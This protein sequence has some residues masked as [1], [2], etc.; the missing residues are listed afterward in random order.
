M[1]STLHGPSFWTSVALVSCVAGLVAGGAQRGAGAG[2]GGR[3]AGGA[4]GAG[5]GQRRG[6]PPPPA[7]PQDPNVFRAGTNLVPLDVRV[8][9][10]KGQPITDLTQAD[11]TVVENGVAQRIEHFA[12]QTMTPDPAL[13]TGPLARRSDQTSAVTPRNYR[14]FLIYLGRGDL[15]GPANGIDG[16]IHFVGERLLPQDRVA[17]FAWNRATDFTTN[18][19][20][21]LAVLQ[22][23]KDGY[24]GVERN[25]SEYFKTPAWMYGNRQIPKNIQKDIDQIFHGPEGAPTRTLGSGEVGNSDQLARAGRAQQERD[26]REN[27]DSFTASSNDTFAAQRVQNLGLT[28]EEFLSQTAQTMQDQANLFAGI[29]YLKH[30]DGE[31]HL[32]MV[33]EQG[34]NMTRWEYDRDLARAASDARVVM[35]VIRTGGTINTGGGG[36]AEL[37]SAPANNGFA[38]LNSLRPAAS[39]AL[40]A[41]L[42]GGRSDANKFSSAARAADAID[43]ASRSQYLIGYYPANQR[44]DG[45]FR[46]INVFVNRKGATVLVRRGYYATDQEGAFDRQSV[47]TYS[48]MIAAAT[49]PTELPDLGLTVT[50]TNSRAATGFSVTVNVTMDVSR[51]HFAQANGRRDGSVEVAVFCLDKKQTPL[52]EVHRTVQLSFTDARYAEVSKAGVPVS[53]TIPVGVEAD[54]VKV[55]AYDYQADLTGSRNFKIEKAK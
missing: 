52:G 49:T 2:Q 53:F 48:R 43:E 13:A 4:R 50:A 31:K 19:D 16:L 14:V 32:L 12:F 51:V 30:L 25:L 27:F 26:V 18:H 36:S 9:D 34:L 6:A 35:D 44:W 54:W 7:A 15:R 10:N 46:T 45:R 55:V 23:F 28:A 1:R 17:I 24:R 22:R 8:L 42:T 37:R 29:E 40:L 47:M 3:G 11:F 33:T 20:T 21:A 41:Q 39:S 5:A 38:A